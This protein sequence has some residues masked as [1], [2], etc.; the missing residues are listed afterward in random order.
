MIQGLLKVLAKAKTLWRGQAGIAAVEFALILPVMLALY[1]G[2]V[3]LSQGLEAGRKTQLLSRTLADLISQQLPGQET[4][5]NCSAYANQPCLLDTD[6]SNYFGAATKVLFPFNG[7]TNM[8]ISEI[9]F[10]NV[11]SANT[12]CCVARVMWSVGMGPSPTLRQCG[13]LTQSA[14]GVNG[15]TL[16]PMGAYPGGQGD[17]VSGKAYTGSGNSTDY[18]LIVADVNYNYNPGFGFQPNSWNKSANGGTGYTIN[19][20]TYMTPRNGANTAIQWTSGGTF[21][22]PAPQSCVKGNGSGATYN[23]EG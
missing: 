2:C 9:I 23:V 22:N 6:L 13:L 15:A 1:F 20:T 21:T 14:N 12:K 11:S 8:T 16:M 17:A 4:T 10:D 5:G 18:Y 19:Q 7:T 3:V